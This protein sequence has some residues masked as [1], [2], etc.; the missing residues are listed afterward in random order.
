MNIEAMARDAGI[1]EPLGY[2]DSIYC[3]E[4]VVLTHM[5]DIAKF[6]ALV[7]A[8]ALRDAAGI[9]NDV[10]MTDS[11]YDG[12]QSCNEAILAAIDQPKEK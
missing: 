2:Y 7:R 9:C 3:T 5:D 6:A 4:E 8:E 11:L 1:S 12:A 10:K